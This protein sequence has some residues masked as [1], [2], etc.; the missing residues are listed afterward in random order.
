MHEV[1]GLCVACS[2]APRHLPL[3][4]F[5]RLVRSL[6]PER[7]VTETARRNGVNAVYSGTLFNL[8]DAFVNTEEEVANDA[9]SEDDAMPAGQR[10]EEPRQRVQHESSTSPA[11]GVDVQASNGSASAGRG[12]DR[13]RAGVAWQPRPTYRMPS[14]LA[15]SPMTKQALPSASN[16]PVP[17]TIPPRLKATNAIQDVARRIG[18][19]QPL[20]DVP[21]LDF[22]D[23]PSLL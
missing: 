5:S 20:E 15:A 3:H 2:L 13:N 9:S 12:G 10:A 19:V 6:R 14:H 21:G 4:C 23:P 7:R 22:G 8:C 17:A 18:K 11:R 1:Q 16:P